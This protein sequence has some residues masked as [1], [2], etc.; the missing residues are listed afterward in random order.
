MKKLLSISLVVFGLAVMAKAQEPV[1]PSFRKGPAGMVEIGTLFNQG[2]SGSYVSVSSG[3]NVLHGLFTG[4]G[5]GVKNQKF[6]SPGVN[7]F[8]V[9]VFAQVR[10]SLLN[11]KFSPFIDLKAGL[12]A[13][14]TRSVKSPVSPYPDNNIGHFFKGAVGVDYKHFSLSVGDDWGTVGGSG[15]YGWTVGLS[16]RF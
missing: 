13:D 14:C 11:K 5:I 7:S 6:L 3:Y 9:P 16:Y 2:Y 12:L 8:L 10:Y 1:N 15:K 4:A